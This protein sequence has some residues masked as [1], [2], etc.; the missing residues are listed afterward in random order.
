MS[1]ILHV[2]DDDEGLRESLVSLLESYDWR[3]VAHASAEQFLNFARPD[4][5]TCL[6]LDVH[7]PGA[8]GLGLQAE[9]KR[10][11]K[12][13]SI[14]FLTGHG[15]IPMTVQAMREGAIEFLTKPFTED[16]L[17]RAIRLAL[18]KE[19]L[20][21]QAQEDLA[22]LQAR[23]GLLTQ[24]EREVFAFVA[25]GTLNKVIAGYLGISEVTVKVHRRRVMDKLAAASLAELVRIAAQLG[26]E[27]PARPVTPSR[28]RHPA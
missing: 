26:V 23:Y 2:V 14:I 9:L 4:G 1:P 24:R 22:A 12:E 25:G 11:G 16:E 8:D 28:E 21:W 20:R 27:K 6:I 7:M 10:L 3:V 13:L 15:T 19:A 18:A 5:P 17:V